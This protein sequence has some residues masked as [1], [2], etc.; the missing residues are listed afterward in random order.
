VFD[1]ALWTDMIKYAAPLIIVGLAGIMDELFSRVMMPVLL[2]GTL[3][4][5][6]AQLGIFAA[7]YKLAMLISFFTQ[8]YRYAAEP[9]FFRHSGDRNALKIQADAAKWF[10]IAAAAGMLGILLF[11][12]LVKGFIDKRYYGGLTVVPILLMANVFL[13]LYYNFSVWYRL[14]DRTPLGAWVS[15]LGA[16]IT[17]VLNYWWI[18]LYGYKGAA[19][20]TLICYAFMSAATWYTGRKP[21]PVP[22]ELGRMALYIGAALGLYYLAE[23]LEPALQSVPALLWILRVL[24]F[25]GFAGMVYGLEIRKR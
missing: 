19:W 4:E 17:V 3:E 11:L 24:L 10:T 2:T 18:P 14:K 12:D 1:R 16:L 7:N 23:W 8:A 22:Y 13:G 21:H 9:F 20:V 15:I 5:N 25:G 6:R